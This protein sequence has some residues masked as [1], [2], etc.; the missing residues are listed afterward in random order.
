MS[1]ILLIVPPG[2]ELDTVPSFSKSDTFSFYNGKYHT[3]TTDPRLTT[4]S[5]KKMN[6]NV[7][8]RETS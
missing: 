8:F 6:E 5:L 3:V 4:M 1:F 2:V 7:F